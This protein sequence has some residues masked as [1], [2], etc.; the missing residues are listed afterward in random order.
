MS[1]VKVTYQCSKCT[2][3][4]IVTEDHVSAVSEKQIE[5]DGC[6]GSFHPIDFVEVE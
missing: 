1:K 3:Q 6:D 2:A 4:R 5:H